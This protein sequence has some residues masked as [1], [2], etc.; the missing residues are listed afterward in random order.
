MIEKI[1]ILSI[2]LTVACGVQ[3]VDVDTA[4]GKIR[5]F[6]PDDNFTVVRFYGIPY[7]KPPIGE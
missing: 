2:F 3:Y 1:L 4:S 7:A 5:G 6:I